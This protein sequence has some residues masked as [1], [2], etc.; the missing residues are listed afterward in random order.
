VR[1]A[2]RWA[3]DNH[4][5]SVTLVHK[6]NIMK[7]TEGAFRK[8][9][10]ALAE[11]EFASQVYTRMQWERTAKEQG[12]AAANAEQAA[13]LNAG[14][15]LVKDAITDATFEISITRPTELDVLATPNLNGD[16]LSDALAAQVGGLGVAPGANINF[17]SGLAIF[18]AA[19]GTAPTLAGLDK[20]N[21]T[22]V[23]LSGEMLLRYLGWTEAARLVIKGLD[24]AFAA[25]TMTFDLCQLLPEATVL[26]TSQ[27]GQA[28]IRHM[29][30]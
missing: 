27:F 11:S 12:E 8:W 15:L 4:R 24:G 21:P 10:Y 7:Y 3:L 19:H 17:E 22:S 28:I 26:S 25:Q 9:G 5:R 13:A 30:D 18:E 23:I 2:I 1:A 6:G 20:V 14:K 16:Y 29:E